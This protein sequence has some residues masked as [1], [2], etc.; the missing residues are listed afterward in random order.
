MNGSVCVE[1]V[2]WFLLKLAACTFLETTSTSSIREG[3]HKVLRLIVIGVLSKIQ[4][5]ML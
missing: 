1:F 3:R 2:L 4:R 5:T